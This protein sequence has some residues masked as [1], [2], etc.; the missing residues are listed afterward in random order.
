MEDTKGKDYSERLA[1]LEGKSWKRILN[2]QAP[3]KWNLSRLQMGRTLDVGCGIGRNLVNLE[4]SV[5]VDHNL[6]SVL[7]AR[8]KGLKA[9]STDEWI[10]SPDAVHGSFD[11]ILLA[12]VLEHL[13]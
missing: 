3:Y 9:Y 7:I 5:G 13:S 2:V 10:S 6:D 12:H 8:S 4:N 1:N 11:S